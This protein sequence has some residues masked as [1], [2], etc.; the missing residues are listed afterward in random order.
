MIAAA[1]LALP[2]LLSS[3]QNWTVLDPAEHRS[4][5]GGYVLY[6]DPSARDGAGPARYRLS[7]HGEALWDAELPFTLRELAVTDAGFTAGYGFTRGD[8]LDGEFLV[9]ILDPRGEVVLQDRKK[10]TESWGLGGRWHA[11]PEGLERSRE[12]TK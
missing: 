10:R 12:A 8:R 9:A 11:R 2:A 1:F 3:P 4:P 5:D 7:R 6:L